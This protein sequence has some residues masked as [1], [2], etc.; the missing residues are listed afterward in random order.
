MGYQGDLGLLEKLG[1]LL[2]SGGN[3]DSV[4]VDQVNIG[5]KRV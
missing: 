4:Q 5:M 1:Y 2:L 3:A